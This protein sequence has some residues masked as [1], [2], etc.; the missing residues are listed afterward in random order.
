MPKPSEDL[1]GCGLHVHVSMVDSEGENAFADPSDPARLSRA[2]SAAVAG[3]LAHAAGQTALGAPTPNS[4]KR[5]LPGS[6]APAHAIWAFG[7]RAALVRVPS[8]DAGRHLEYRSGDMGANL[9]LHVTG[10]LAAIVDRMEG[11]EDAPPPVQADVGHLADADATAIGADRLPARLDAALDALEADQVL[12]AA[13]GPLIVRHYLAVKRFEWS[14]YVAGSGLAA[15]D[16]RV[17]DWERI[18]YLEVL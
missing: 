2:G 6:W 3:L 15:D 18:A 16:V 11:G 14:S 17:S 12:M 4:F 5:L 7:N 9:Y 8:M 13:L 10:L 1:P